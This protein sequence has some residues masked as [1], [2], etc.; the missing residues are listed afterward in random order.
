ML[1]K[2]VLAVI[3][4]LVLIVASSTYANADS[5]QQASAKDL[6][7]QRL[8]FLTHTVQQAYID[9]GA[10]GPSLGDYQVFS[11]E[12]FKDSRKVGT[13][14]GT[15]TVTNVPTPGTSGGT[16]SQC[17]VTSWLPKGQITTLGLVT[18]PAQGLPEPF[19]VAIT[20][21]TG[22]YRTARGVLTVTFLSATDTTVAF[23]LIL[24]SHD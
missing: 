7:A 15:C 3:F 19:T 18:F 12:L 23:D 2:L 16:T 13:D 20:G 24:G 14:G 17:L 6:N 8:V 22:A 21:G 4:A 1:K 11:H 5:T 10:Q 9:V